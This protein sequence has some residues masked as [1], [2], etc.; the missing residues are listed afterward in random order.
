MIRRK[1]EVL[2]NAHWQWLSHPTCSKLPTGKLPAVPV[3]PVVHGAWCIVHSALVHGVWCMVQ[4]CKL[5]Q[6]ESKAW[7]S[8][9][10]RRPFSRDRSLFFL[11]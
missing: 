10:S 9:G 2:G 7:S 5:P 4:W 1:S 3:A 11:F 8:P 6:D